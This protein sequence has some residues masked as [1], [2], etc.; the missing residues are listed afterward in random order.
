MKL[1]A[2]L[3]PWTDDPPCIPAQAANLS[4]TAPPK[5]LLP[6]TDRVSPTEDQLIL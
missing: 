1:E 3:T 6:K 4:S 5:P 2:E